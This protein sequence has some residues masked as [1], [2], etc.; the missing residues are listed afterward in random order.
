[1]E[2]SHI[3]CNLKKKKKKSGHKGL[4]EV[5]NTFNPSTQEEKAVCEFKASLVY[6]G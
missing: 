2:K 3:V 4:G 6:I 1:M 5:S